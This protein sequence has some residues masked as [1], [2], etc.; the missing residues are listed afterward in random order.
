MTSTGRIIPS[1]SAEWRAARG[2][3]A[4]LL[5]D[6]L[7]WDL[8]G[9]RWHQVQEAVA[10]MAAAAATQE[11]AALYRAIGLLDLCGPDRVATR[12]GA[13]QEDIARLPAPMPVRER[14]AE[15]VDTLTRQ[16]PRVGDGPCP[17]HLRRA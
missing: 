7:E 5:R 14:I 4:A 9:P 12:L 6:A 8:P 3:A 17:D 1:R 13:H 16:E 15:L 11:T 10:D 2:Q